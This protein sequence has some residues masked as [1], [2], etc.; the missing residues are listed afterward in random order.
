MPVYLVTDNITG[1]RTMVEASR[2]AG[3]LSTLIDN[4]FDVSPA[5]DATDALKHITQGVAYLAGAEGE[6]VPSEAPEFSEV[7]EEPTTATARPSL[8]AF[9]SAAD[10][11]EQQEEVPEY[12]EP[13]P[14]PSGWSTEAEEVAE[15]LR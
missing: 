11:D 10:A 2:P 4:R 8:E 12:D 15:Q 3:A 1:V 13:S 6:P 7:G 14:A 9:A 5:L